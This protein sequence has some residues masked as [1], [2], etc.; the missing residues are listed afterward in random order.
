MQSG[1]NSVL[2][3]A[4]GVSD[5]SVSQFFQ[6]ERENL[7]LSDREQSNRCVQPVVLTLSRN[8]SLWRGARIRNINRWLCLARAATHRLSKTNIVG[9]A[10]DIRL[11]GRLTAVPRQ[12]SHNRQ[13]NLLAEFF[14]IRTRWRIASDNSRQRGAVLFSDVVPVVHTPLV[15]GHGNTFR[16]MSKKS[17]C[18][19][20]GGRFLSLS[21]L[22]TQ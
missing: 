12:C 20:T 13:G 11:Y 3:D 16:S 6:R 22:D 9:N 18:G 14:S 17:R 4:E 1:S 19:A 15:H 7:P 10:Q 2:T 8:N 21:A 5:L